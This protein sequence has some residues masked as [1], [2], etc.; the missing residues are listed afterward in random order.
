MIPQGSQNIHSR[1]HISE[2][3]AEVIDQEIS[4]LL[5]SAYERAKKVLIENKENLETLAKVLL[6]EGG[7]FQGRPGGDIR[8][9]SF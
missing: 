2:K 5:E 4:K 1:N 6:G 8:K 3:T 7:D 9:T